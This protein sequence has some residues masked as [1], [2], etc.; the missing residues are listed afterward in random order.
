LTAWQQHRRWLISQVVLWVAVVVA[1]RV[2]VVPAESCPPVALGDL[3][4][5]LAAG[6]AWLARGQ[7][8]DGRFRY[9]YDSE[10]GQL[11][12][13]YNTTRHA[14]VMDALYRLGRVRAADRG[15]RY[16]REN[17][18][19]ADGWAALAPPGE[20]A[21]AG[22]NALLV[23]ALVHR[24]ERT[25]ESRYDGLI[26]RLARF[27]V[28]QEQG[29]GSVLQ[30]WDPI[31]RRPVEGLYGK[32]STGEAFYALALVGRIAP[33]EVWDSTAHRIGDYLATRR[34]RAEGYSLREPD[35]W[36]AYGLDALAPAGLTETEV[37]YGR[38][39][40]GYF[41]W[42]IRLES[43]HRGRMLNP[44]IESGAE[45]GTIG[46]ASA[47]LWR[48]SG[49]DPRLADLRVDLGERIECMAGVL[50]ARQRPPDDP[51]PRARGAWFADGYTQMD[52]QQ[53]ALAAL[54]GA[55]EVMRAEA[56]R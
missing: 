11:S 42:L 49:A 41:G 2:A 10:N 13:E 53:H 37:E 38:W 29:D 47:A 12:A 23:V 7:G 44:F 4:R 48:L 43:Q 32:F 18:I 8:A 51:D 56:A 40:A 6:G 17:L 19:H 54:L 21:N 30:F 55:R 22:V 34:D 45:L 31:T 46:E 24:R 26:E 15:L 50:V 3:D 5:A 28:A 52:D 25:G 27:L 20:Q 35:H 36:A 16:A 39:L 9:G 1:L 14:G 33:G